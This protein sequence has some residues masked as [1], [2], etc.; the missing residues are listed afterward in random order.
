MLWKNKLMSVGLKPLVS[1][2][3]ISGIRIGCANAEIKLTD[4]PDFILFEMSEN[5]TTAAVFTRNAFCAAPVV[6]AREH[7]TKSTPRY[8]IVNSGNANAG[9]GE[10]GYQASLDCCQ[11][12]ANFSGCEATEVLPFSTGV[13]GQL[14]PS[15]K[16]IKAIPDAMKDL[17][18]NHWVAAA[19]AM[20]TTD[21]MAKGATRTIDVN[22]QTVNLT[23]IVKGAG[24][25]RPD[26]A[27]M[28]CYIGT[29][30]SLEKMLLQGFLEKAVDV[31]FNCATVDGDTSTN[32]SCVL[33]ATAAST[34]I[35]QSDDAACEIFAEAL[36][37][38]CCELAE[39]MIRDAE[40]ANKFVT[41]LVEGGDSEEEVREVA[42]CIAHS[43]LV[44]TAL[45]A[46]DP[47]WGRILAAVGR[48]KVAYLDVSLINIYLNNVCIVQAGSVASTYTED[49]GQAVMDGEDIT[50]RVELAR[51]GESCRVW[52]SDLS[53]DYVKINAEYRT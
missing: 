53:Y 22:G 37:S 47:N 5:S 33:V 49:A 13:I 3:A 7:L 18:D 29:D 48:A 50:I 36:T 31:S 15:E 12:V 51:G 43:P 20:M 27:T 21:T 41:I 19:H 46:G 9:T 14:L 4:S 45:F 1:L 42:D 17:Q 44:K 10:A 8:L 24:M 23:G 26:M 52:T 38:L 39:K 11:A 35:S 6:I 30:A 32:D 2:E 40:G 34:E 25:I 16:I 28:L